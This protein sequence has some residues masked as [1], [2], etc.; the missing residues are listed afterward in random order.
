MTF[1]GAEHHV[2]GS[3][4]L[5]SVGQCVPHGE[6]RILNTQGREVPRGVVGEIC[7]RGPNVMV[8]YYKMPE[9]TETTL[10]DGWLRTGDGGRMNEHGFV[11]I[12]DRI[13]DVIVSGGESVYSQEVEQCL[14]KLEGVLQCA[15]IGVP[16]PVLIEKVAAIV[17]VKPNSALTEEHVIEHCRQRIAKYKCPRSVFFR[18]DPLPLSGAGKVLKSALREPFW[19]DVQNG[20]IYAKDDSARTSTYDSADGK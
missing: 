12:C 15:V 8:G 6:L 19:K 7:Y 10:R 20:S 4:V 18:T 9:T 3:P 17:V 11:F 5:T 13:K 14:S 1:L 16:D 2:V